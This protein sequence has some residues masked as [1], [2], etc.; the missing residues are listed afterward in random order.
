MKKI[1]LVAVGLLAFSCSKKAEAT[2][3]KESTTLIEEPKQEEAKLTPLEEGKSLV[4]GADCL[5]CH[6]V[7]EKM[8]GP[9]YEEVAAK[10]ENTPENI[11]ALAE[12]IIQGSSGVWGNV[13]MAAHPG[14]SKENAKLMASYVLSL[15]K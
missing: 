1:L 13:P 2:D 15:K 6:K 3:S 14:L 9:A 8:I 10:Y 5:A 7:N 4:E 12:K 11:D